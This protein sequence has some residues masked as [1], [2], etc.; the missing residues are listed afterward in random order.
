MG[1]ST[2]L[3]LLSENTGHISTYRLADDSV[4][5]LGPG[6]GS[7]IGGLGLPRTSKEGIGVVRSP[8]LDRPSMCIFSRF[9][10]PNRNLLGKD[11]S[12]SSSVNNPCQGLLAGDT[13]LHCGKISSNGG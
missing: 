3:Q 9:G 5:L 1:F 6:K 7:S 10:S 4:S 11:I 8:G 12:L 13:V 2:M